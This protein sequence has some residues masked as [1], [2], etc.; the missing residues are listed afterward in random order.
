LREK[1]GLR[2]K[3]EGEREEMV[4]GAR[5]ERAEGAERKERVKGAR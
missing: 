4:K 3:A 5:E 1:R 2:A